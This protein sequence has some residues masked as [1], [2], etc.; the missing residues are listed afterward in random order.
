MKILYKS[1]LLTYHARNALL[2][3]ENRLDAY[4]LSVA[5]QQN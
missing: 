2:K 5:R 3:A 4:L 1:A